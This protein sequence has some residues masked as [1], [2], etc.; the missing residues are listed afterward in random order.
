MIQQPEIRFRTTTI[1]NSPSL[2]PMCLSKDILV[3]PRF[4]AFATIQ[5]IPL[6]I[7]LSSVNLEIIVG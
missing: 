3:N 6:N 2:M 5:A 4:P 1:S 7:I